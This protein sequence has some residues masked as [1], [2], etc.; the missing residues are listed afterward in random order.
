[1][2]MR[3]R[4]KDLVRHN[5]VCLQVAKE[6]ASDSSSLVHQMISTGVTT[7]RLD[8]LCHLMGLEVQY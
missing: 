6:C 5:P 2:Q 8:K 4:H 1:M 7:A 3:G